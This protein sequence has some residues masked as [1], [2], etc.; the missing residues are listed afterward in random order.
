VVEGGPHENWELW[1]SPANVALDGG[2]EASVSAERGWIAE[3][4]P[5]REW[6]DSHYSRE[7]DRIAA[8]DR[9]TVPVT[10]NETHD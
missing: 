3:P 4:Q 5:A 6:H 7:A 2:T 1:P 8:R 10:D 9:G